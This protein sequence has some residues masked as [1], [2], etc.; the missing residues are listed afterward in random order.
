M[1]D[2]NPKL[3]DEPS[4]FYL[5][6][7]TSPEE[8]IL[9]VGITRQTP[10]QRFSGGYKNLNIEVLHEESLPLYNAYKLERQILTTLPR[11]TPKTKFYGWTE[12]LD[13]KHRH[14]VQDIVDKKFYL[15]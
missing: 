11:K 12:C 4:T 7:I 2:R 8:E 13:I 14:A 10:E 6:K 5:V 9:K 1:F 3:K 15:T